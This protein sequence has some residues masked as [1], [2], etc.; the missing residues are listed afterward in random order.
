[1]VISVLLYL[2]TGAVLYTTGVFGINVGRPQP[3]PV[4][5]ALV[6]CVLWLPTILLLLVLWAAGMLEWEEGE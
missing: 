6:S 2:L 5:S 3:N 1:M 4:M